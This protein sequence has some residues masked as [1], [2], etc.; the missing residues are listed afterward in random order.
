[1]LKIGLVGSSQLSFPGDKKTV[2]RLTSD[3]IA[4]LS[5]NLGFELF[6]YKDTV[7][8]VEDGYAAVKR[9]EEERVDFV[10]LQCTSFS[11]GH[12]A[13]IFARTKNAFLGLW[14]IP[15]FAEDGVVPFNS[16]C[17]INM[18]SSI[19]GHYLKDYKIPLKWFYGD[20]EDE[21]FINRFRVT[22]RALSA[23][24]KLKASNIALVGGIAPGFNDLYDDERNI[25]KCLDGIRINRLHEYSEIRDRA[26]SYTSEDIKPYLDKMLAEAV[27]VQKKAEPLLETSARFAKA[28][29][30]FVSEYK[31]DALAIS[32]WPK[33][34]DEFKYS[35]CS[36][37]A[38]LNDKGVVA[39]CEGD[40]LSAISMLML[41]YISDDETMLMDLSAFDR[42]DDTVLMWHC[43]PA[44]SRFCSDKGYTLGVN[45]HGM[46]H[47]EGCEEPNCCGVTRDMVF[48]PHDVTIA[49]FTGECDKMFVA[50]GK[51]TTGKKSF[52]G[53]RGWLGQLK[54]NGE[55]ISALD[56]VNT[57]LVQRFQHHYPIVRG[58]YSK[59]V[60]EV[61]AWL[62]L[63]SIKKVEY[64][65]YMQNPMA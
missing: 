45:Y 7:I 63:D 27:G 32:C 29:D 2:F 13:P 12:L 14:A 40:V 17:S 31:Y 19:I 6:I 55:N 58:D 21:L 54:L 34:Q 16:F 33:F 59:E 22:V 62:G 53:S 18:Y 8:T 65:D 50:Q 42:K 39:S 64:K 3:K 28:Y 11:A 44:S 57:I 43:G 56:L 10:L 46:A 47:T 35:V 24:K 9:L 25:I 36:V 52:H 5:K 41:K 61:M 15:E 23:I 4:Q 20:V 38:G 49:R 60:F 48:A 30:D 37:V 51:F 1:M 26:S